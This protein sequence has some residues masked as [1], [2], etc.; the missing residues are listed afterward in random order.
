MYR[1]F[2]ISLNQTFITMAYTDVIT[3]ER[4]K[5]YLRIDPDLTEDDAEITSMINGACIYV[6]KR[7]NLI[8]FARDIDY[9]G[10]CQVKVYDAPI[11][12]IITDPAPWFIERT[13]YTIYPDVKAVKLNVGYGA[14]EVPD[15][16]I[17]EMLRIISLWY[18]DSEKKIKSELIYNSDIINLHR[19]FI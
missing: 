19:R 9:K 6:E 12:A 11:N 10:S 15:D 1:F 17:E 4:A 13:A 18:Y 3:L 2:F 7:T 5:N 16:L 14:N 8:L